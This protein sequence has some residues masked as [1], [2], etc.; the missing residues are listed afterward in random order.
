LFSLISRIACTRR[1]TVA[2]MAVLVVLALAFVAIGFVEYATRHLFLNPKV[3]ASNQFES[4][5][6]VTSLFFAPNI[7]GRFLAIVML[8]VAT[9][10]LWAKRGRDV[11]GSAIV[12]A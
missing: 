2:C 7:Y 11:V 3:I 5:F 1:L 12:L 6:R 9:V 8:G 10:L 4:Y